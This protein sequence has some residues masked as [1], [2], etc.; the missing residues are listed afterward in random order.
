MSNFARVI[1][2]IDMKDVKRKRLEEIA[3][4]KLK[5]ERDKKEKE[6]IKEISRK[7]KSDWKTELS[8]KMTTGAVFTTTIAPAED[9]GTV[10][11]VDVIDASSYSGTVTGM[12]GA[13]AK[14]GNTGSVIRDSGSG[15]GQDGGFDV[16]GKYLSFQGDGYNV[17]GHA[18]RWAALAPIDSSRISSLTITA[19]VGND[20]NGGEDPDASAE[21]LRVMYKTPSMDTFRLIVFNPSGEAV[22]ATNSDIIIPLG[23]SGNSGLN[24]YSV[25]IPEWAREKDTQFALI[26]LVSSGTGFDNYGITKI[27]FQR[28][29]PINVVV[30]LDD[31]QAVSFIRVG[32][33]EGDPKKRKKKLN[34]QLAAAD[35]Y[36]QAQLGDEFPGAGT[37]VGGD[38]PFAS[39]KI[40]DDVE[41]SPIGKDE[42]KKSFSKF[43]ADSA[44]ATTSDTDADT[45]QVVIT[46]SA[47]TTMTPTNDDGDP[48]PVKSV[49]GKTS[50]AIQGADAAD[51]DTQE[52]EPEPT[53]P[54]PEAP[55]LDPED[56]KASEEEKQDKTPEE[57]EKIENEKFN[58]KAD[59]TADYINKLIDFD[60]NLGLS[61]F[62]AFAQ[63]TGVAINAVI[64]VISA[65]SLLRG[66]TTVADGDGFLGGL[67]KIKNSIDIA[68][69]VLSG[70]VVNT[71]ILPQEM[72]SFI[73]SLKVDEFATKQSGN[74]SLNKIM[75]SDVRHEYADDNIYVKDGKVYQNGDGKDKRGLY[76][77]PL[78]GSG[79]AGVGNHGY[80]Y[81]QMIIPKDGS[82]PYL[83]YY[84]HNYENLNNIGDVSATGGILQTMKAEYPQKGAG[85][86]LKSISNIIHQLKGDNIKFVPQKLRESL[87]SYFGAFDQVY[88]GLLKTSSLEGFPPGIHGSALTDFKVP[89]SKLPKETQEMIAKHPLSWTP[90]RIENMS[91]EQVNEQLY[92]LLTTNEQFENYMD[93]TSDITKMSTEPVNTVP[94]AVAMQEIDKIYVEEYEP[95]QQEFEE[96]Q[97]KGYNESPFTEA[98][99]AAYDD[100]QTLTAQMEKDSDE[101]NRIRGV[102]AQ[103]DLW[104]KLVKPAYDAFVKATKNGSVSGN[105]PIKKRLEKQHAKWK[106]QSDQMEAEAA[107]VQSEYL[108]KYYEQMDKISEFYNAQAVSNSIEGFEGYATTVDEKGRGDYT[109]LDGRVITSR[110]NL[111]KRHVD[112]ITEIQDRI[113]ELYDPVAD[114]RKFVDGA[115]VRENIG[116]QF[117]NEFGFS[118]DN[119]SPEKKGDGVRRSGD[120]PKPKPKPKPRDS[121]AGLDDPIIGLGADDGDLLASAGYSI[122]DKKNVINLQ[123]KLQNNPNY[124]PKPYELESLQR[125]MRA[126]QNQGSMVAHYQPKGNHLLEKYAR[127]QPRRDLFERVKQKQ[128]FNPKDIKPVFP[129]NPPPQLDPKTG[130][131]PEYGKTAKRYRKLDPISANAMPPTGDPETDAV[132]DKQRTKPKPKLFNKL[133]KHTRKGLTDK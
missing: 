130:M 80:G 3:A 46:P 14:S 4:K 35:E 105:S 57:V 131:H 37:R 6:L 129:E 23:A 128:F 90:E 40:G 43:S 65:A 22:G 51:V 12:L 82:E 112:S 19:I 5:E 42:V 103:L 122:E 76:A 111:V 101:N 73:K 79:F 113:M 58:A 13:D 32:T 21:D 121:Y 125:Q 72:N 108:E 99:R 107:R 18:I 116:G 50:G 68:R 127:P 98:E 133:K 86:L 28:K 63:V 60:L 67:G 10:N 49:G 119:W 34:D 85:P 118:S 41:P 89:L 66:A 87:V 25:E 31:P 93:F 88:E 124:Q 104:D 33:D 30:P 8:E 109:T 15:S 84:D 75:I 9:D 115:Y 55:E 24:N 20:S 26:Q 100:M 81:A 102:S 92:P 44:S 47:Q 36:T 56:L 120:K 69:G 61:S 77:T 110:F 29:T 71:K 59:E 45:T 16:G 53:Q 1:H 91:D 94:F 117:E 52:P 39:A 38:D 114:L 74:Q 95:I 83:H 17:S 106:K 132:V 97:G 11:A 126:Q 7:Y 27:N 123:K 70:K 54:E 78:A 64:S 2:H 62:N 48:I 96:N